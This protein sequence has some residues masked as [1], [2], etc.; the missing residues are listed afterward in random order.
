[1]AKNPYFLDNTSEQRLVEDLTEET[2]RSMGRD[3]YYIPR[4]NFNN[5]LLFGEDPV[6]KFKGSHKIEMYINSVQ[7]FDGQGDIVSKFGIQLKDRV[8]LV[9]STRRFHELIT[10]TNVSLERPR[11]GDLIYFP[12]SDTLFEINFVEHENPFYPLGKRYTFVLTCEA[13]TYS[14]ED[15][16]TEQNFIDDV[17]TDNQTKGFEVYID[18]AFTGDYTIGET[19]YQVIGNGPTGATLSNADGI[20]VVYDWN[21]KDNDSKNLVL[22]GNM[23]GSFT[24]GNG[25]YLICVSSGSVGLIDNSGRLDIIIPFNPITNKALLDNNIIEKEKQDDDIINFSDID[26][27]SEGDYWC[28]IFIIINL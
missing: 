10:R 3:V 28:L 1:M 9:V 6:A 25:V 26:P 27:F 14:N 18:S 7:G 5:D 13:F 22:I 12:L 11:E 20:G 21:D 23:S 16:E 17:Q 15:I 24:I 2:I 4:V 8:E 19:I